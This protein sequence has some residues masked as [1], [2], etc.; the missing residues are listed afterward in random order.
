L[1]LALELLYDWG[2]GGIVWLDALL[3]PTFFFL[4]GDSFFLSLSFHACRLFFL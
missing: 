1:L 2:P 3:T 4:P